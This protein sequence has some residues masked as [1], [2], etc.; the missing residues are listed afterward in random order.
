MQ[1]TVRAHDLALRFKRG[2]VYG[3]LS[4]EA[5]T[6]LTVLCGPTGSG[7]TSLMLTL[8]GRMKPSEGT[9][10]VLGH[11]L[12][13]RA[14]RVQKRTGISGFH[15]IDTLEES[16]T[17]GAA[18]RER[19]AWISPWW[20]FIRTVDDAAVRRACAAA[21]GD[22]PIP[23]ADTVIWDLDEVQTVL[24]RAALA[25]MNE[26]SILFFDQVEQVHEPESRRILWQRL[27]ALA[28]M[29]TSVIASATAPETDIWDEL[30]IWP[31][32][33]M[34]NKAVPLNTAVPMD[35]ETR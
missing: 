24:L 20:A 34:M 28:A 23:A 13:K 35:Q 5:G 1:S 17:V 18:I 25:L 33:V 7:R 14:R 31:T 30:G 4:F 32:I 9:L 8:A 19:T 11:E 27:A 3:P 29:G 16:V 26:P 10:E 12:P 22:V 21:F 15:D 6:G 2:A